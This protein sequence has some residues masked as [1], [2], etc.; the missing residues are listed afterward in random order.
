MLRVLL[1]NDDGIRAEGIRT[2]A[3]HL[4]ERCDVLVVAPETASSASSHSIT[5]HKPL[6]LREVLDFQSIA[7]IERPVHPRAGL[8][9]YMCSGKP[10]DCVTLG[11]LHQAKAH[12]PHLVI[13]GIN[14]GCNVAEDLTYSGTV[15][16]ALE[17]AIL[18]IPS[19][20]VSLDSDNGGNFSEAA[21]LT[22]LLIGILA[23]GQ[24]FPWHGKLLSQL[25]DACL[26]GAFPGGWRLDAF[27]QCQ[28]DHYPE[29]GAWHAGLSQTPCLNVNFPGVD[30]HELQGFMWAAGGTREYREVIQQAT[31]PQ[32]RGYFWV[33]G[34][35]VMD[36][37][38]TP[39]TDTYGLPRG[40]ATIT[41]LSYDIT[42]HRALAELKA[43][44][45][46]RGKRVASRSSHE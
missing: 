19:L 3:L 14:D 28:L 15:G 21:A 44:Q 33:G 25:S 36:E 41:P 29:P 12:P 40:F 32:G 38:E 43:R 27:P 34:T 18:G 16:A 45:V 46:E 31:D 20:A 11:V 10:A 7:G 37:L 24:L 5:L 30:L 39:E 2:L 26:E 6:R 8:G 17:G 35:K 23:Y 13:S 1:T 42:N 9:A 22:D 4:A